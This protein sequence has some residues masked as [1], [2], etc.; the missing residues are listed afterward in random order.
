MRRRSFLLGSV[1]AAVAAG[2]TLPEL[3]HKLLVEWGRFIGGR[4]YGAQGVYIEGV[5]MG[6]GPDHTDWVLVDADGVVRSPP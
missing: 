4:F 5:D 6:N 2:L 1:A 3:E